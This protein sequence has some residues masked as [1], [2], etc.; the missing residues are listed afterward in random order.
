MIT[1]KEIVLPPLDRGFHLITEHILS[2]LDDFP[3]CGVMHLFLQHTSCGL[4]LNENCD[5]SVREDFEK[6]I[7]LL[8]KEDEPHYTHTAEGVDDMPAHIK[9]TLIGHSVS[10]PISHGHLNLGKWQGIYFCEFR[11]NPTARKIIA[12]IYH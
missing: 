10:I 11:N 1:Q 5:P 12:T 9:S 8:I 6:S 3:L 2:N 7:N 4:T